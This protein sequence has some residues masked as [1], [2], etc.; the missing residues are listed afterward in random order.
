[1]RPLISHHQDQV[2]ELLQIIVRRYV[3]NIAVSFSDFVSNLSS[4]VL[5]KHNIR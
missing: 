2:Q 4:I 5:A 3:S 1:M